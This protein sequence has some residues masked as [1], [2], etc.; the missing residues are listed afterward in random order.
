MLRL[1]NPW[2][3][4]RNRSLLFGITVRQVDNIFLTYKVA[5]RVGKLSQLCPLI[6]TLNQYDSN[7]T[8][9]QYKKDRL[10]D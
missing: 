2:Y 9:Q 10:K 4:L 6:A 1:H 5:H 3:W 8:R 7:L